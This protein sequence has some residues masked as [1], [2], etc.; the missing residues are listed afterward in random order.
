MLSRRRHNARLV[1]YFLTEVVIVAA[2][3]FAGY[4]IRQKTSGFWRMDVVPVATIL[5]L[6]P[7]TVVLWAALLWVPYSY[8]GF[9][10]R[11]GWMHAFTAAVT[12]TIGVLVL[13]AV[14]ALVKRGDAVNRSLIGLIGVTIFA[15]LTAYRLAARSLLAHYT[16]QGYDRH[17][18]V[19]GGTGDEAVSLAEMLEGIQGA[20]FEV[21]GFVSE[22]GGVAGSPV[23]RWTLL[24]AYK[25]LPSLGSK[26]PVDDVFLIPSGGPLEQHVDLIHQCETMGMTVHLKLAPFERMISRLELVEAAGGDY[27]K[28]TTTPKNEAALVAKRILDVA[29]A[30]L[31]LILLTPLLLLVALLVKLTSKGPVIFLQQRAGMNGRAFTLY[32]FRTM[33]EGAEKERETLQA[34]NELDGPA[35]KI[36][37]DPRITPLGKILRMTSID[38]FPQ[39]WNVIRGDMSLVGPRPLPLYEV[40]KFEPWQRRRMSMRPGITCLWQISGRSRVISFAEWMKLDLEYVDRWSLG[41]DLQILLRTVPAV[42]GARGAY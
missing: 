42:L 29:A 31:A 18:V 25:D 7:T 4:W 34:Q 14:V 5:W 8:V 40:E 6:L 30:G 15:S 17:Y 3:F 35:F 20:V 28:F 32:K 13:F 11:S 1:G 19:I 16:R 27:L 22:T 33:V 41:L 12:S 26:M 23:G 36:K 10:S 37:R 24:G 21:R 2:A 9:R 38:E 39:F